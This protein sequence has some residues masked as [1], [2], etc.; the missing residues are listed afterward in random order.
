[1]NNHHRL[2]A[3]LV[4]IL[5]TVYL[6]WLSFH[7]TGL[8]GVIFLFAELLI[9]SLALL[10]IF[11]HSEQDH[12]V[13]TQTPARGSLDIFIPIVD[14][15]LSL[16]KGTL[17]AALE[18]DYQNKRVYILDD[19]AREEISKLAKGVGAVYLSR[20]HRLHSKAGNLNFA[21]SQSQG[22]YVLVLDADQVP[23][24]RIASHLLGHFSEDPRLAVI[25]TRQSFN[26]PE[27]DFNHDPLFYE[28][29]QTGKNDNNAAV[30]CGSGV[31]YRRTALNEVGGF[32]TWNVVEDVYTTYVLH[33]KGFRSLYVNQPY[34]RGTAP[35]DLPTIFKQ[36]GTWALDTLR[37]FFH[38]LLIFGNKLTFRQWIHYFEFGWCYITSA[39]A[40]PILSI[41][42]GLALITGDYFITEPES[43]VVL[44][45]ISLLPTLYFYYLLGGRNS[46]SSQFWA[47]LFPVYLK[48][49]ILSLFTG[50][51]TYKVTK[52]FN[53][54][55]RSDIIFIFPHLSLIVFNVG[56]II[57][58]I[59]VSDF[60]FTPFI[61]INLIWVATLFFWFA[62]ILRKGLFL[63]RVPVS[64]LTEE[65]LYLES[66]S[67]VLKN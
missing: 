10:F 15:P 38:R 1:M 24:S 22:E 26:V 50:K 42:P 36:R 33:S 52:K 64:P 2:L 34:S 41:F 9:G 44:R 6:I 30:S 46:S 31:F 45:L 8:M 3:F 12:V 23:D 20:G 48:A 5:N 7:V 55:K 60:V 65:S 17:E 66:K 37:L 18:I 61:L 43:Y 14:E 28:H 32:Q 25:V 56:A 58:R 49:L 59:T 13:L 21:L 63:E 51:P 4:L 67:S 19:G 27:G 11:N 39:I 16:F 47:A 62:P 35:Q 29:M 54:P 57:F 53:D 40:I